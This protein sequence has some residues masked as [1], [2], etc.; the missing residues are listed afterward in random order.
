MSFEYIRKLPTPDEI[1][2]E[3]PFPA[4]LTELKKKRDE[5]IRKVSDHRPLFR[6]Q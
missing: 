2:E 6:R 5:E 1:R 3:F 4:H